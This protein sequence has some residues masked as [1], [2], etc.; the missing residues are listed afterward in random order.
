LHQIWN[1][2]SIRFWFFFKFGVHNRI[3]WTCIISRKLILS[4]N[5]FIWYLF[6]CIYLDLKDYYTYTKSILCKIILICQISKHDRKLT[7]VTWIKYDSPS[8][9]CTITP[10]TASYNWCHVMCS[11]VLGD[12]N[13]ICSLSV[14]GKYLSF[15]YATRVFSLPVLGL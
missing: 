8:E 1:S 4:A 2:R 9:W 5:W 3:F 15:L 7:S 13:N 10:S 12:M 14:I 11:V 6:L